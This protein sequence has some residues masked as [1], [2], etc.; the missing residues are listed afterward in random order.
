M[1]FGARAILRPMTLKNK[2]CLLTV[3]VVVTF[4]ATAFAQDGG[5]T[6]STPLWVSLVAILVGYASHAYNTGEIFGQKTLPKAWLPY[7]GALATFGTAFLTA[8]PSGATLSKSV[9]EVAALSGLQALVAMAFGVVGHVAQTA[10][11]S[12]RGVAAMN[13]SGSTST[14]VPPT[15]PSNDVAKSVPPA[16]VLLLIVLATQNQACIDSAPI[17]PETAANQSQIQTCQ[18]TAELHNGVVIGD[19]ALG[20]AGTALASAAAFATD[21]NTKNTL[22]Y[23]G[24]GTGAAV[25]VGTAIA[26]YTSS[27]FANSNCSS[28]VGALPSVT[29]PAPTAAPTTAPVPA[30]NTTTVTVAPVGK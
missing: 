16:A 12:S 1:S 10:H 17:V 2:L 4:P 7:V 29:K 25:I 26:G 28:V 3:A 5:I 20:G 23:V 11:K 8:L 19:F 9:L 21:T 22:A 14:T 18:S 24:I 13:G 27:N 15:S 6:S 30:N